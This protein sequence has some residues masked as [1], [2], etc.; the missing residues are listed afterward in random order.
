MDNARKVKIENPQPVRIFPIRY[1]PHTV[2]II[3]KPFWVFPHV[4]DIK[5]FPRRNFGPDQNL[6]VEINFHTPSASCPCCC[7]DIVTTSAP[8]GNLR[9]L[10][11]VVPKASAPRTMSGN[12]A[13]ASGKRAEGP[14]ALQTTSCGD[15][16]QIGKCPEASRKLLKPRGSCAEGVPKARRRCGTV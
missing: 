2:F 13:K 4:P 5:K 3:P 15:A 12:F 8:F 14:E 10:L 11:S 9:H 1:P 7:S 6:D 16:E